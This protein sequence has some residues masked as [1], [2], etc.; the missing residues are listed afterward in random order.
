MKCTC[1]KAYDADHDWWRCEVHGRVT[2]A[3][4]EEEYDTSDTKPKGEKKTPPKADPPAKKARPT[5]E[6]SEKKARPVDEEDTDDSD[7]LGAPP[8]KDGK[9]D[10]DGGTPK[11]DKPKGF[12]WG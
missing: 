5:S 12:G 8:D 6:A 11:S 10:K 4:Y 7:D 9:A 3:E 2:K 1:H